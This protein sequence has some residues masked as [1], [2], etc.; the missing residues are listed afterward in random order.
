MPAANPASPTSALRSPPPRRST[1]L[2]GH[3]RKTRAPTMTMKPMMKRSTGLEPARGLKSPL[4]T[5]I[6][7][8]PKTM[9]MISGRT[10]STI[11][12]VCRC[13]A[14]AIS[15]MKHAMQK[16]ILAGFPSATRITLM[17]PIAAPVAARPAFPD[18]LMAGNI[19]SCK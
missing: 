19:P 16:P 2:S 7:N 10:Y 6:A 5:L 3:P 9:P 11:G 14:P 13:I 17:I 4:M 8:E 18:I 12:A 15:L 1:I